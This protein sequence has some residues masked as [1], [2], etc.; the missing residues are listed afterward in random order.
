[1]RHTLFAEVGSALALALTL[2]LAAAGAVPALATTP[3]TKPIE[4]VWSGE[5][6]KEG[7]AVP[8]PLT[9]VIRDKPRGEEA[10][11]IVWGSPFVC[12]TTL[13]FSSV[14]NQ[15]YLLSVSGGNGPAC[16]AL[17]DGHV[18]V[19]QDGGER[20]SLSIYNSKDKVI[21]KTRVERE[22]SDVK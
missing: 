11:E 6:V 17:V 7:R 13:H 16:D 3:T 9:M 2:T 14:K 20:A 5:V 10:G 4:G 18:D 12:K 19:K 21:Y 8:I 22:K 15:T 1:M